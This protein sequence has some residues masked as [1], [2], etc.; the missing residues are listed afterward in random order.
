MGV[1]LSHRFKFARPR[2]SKRSFRKQRPSY[3]F[4]CDTLFLNSTERESR[5][6]YQKHNLSNPQ[7]VREETDRQATRT[8]E[9]VR[10]ESAEEEPGKMRAER[11]YGRN[12][13]YDA[14]VDRKREPPRYGSDEGRRE[15]SRNISINSFKE[16][17]RPSPPGSDRSF[18][19]DA[20]VSVSR[21]CSHFYYIAFSH[22]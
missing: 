19:R 8:S 9:S 1:R 16:A 17:E 3:T 12:F 10:R 13:N 14:Y 6:G 11:Q 5:G 21:N 18:R 15:D 7:W 2:S 20:E 4:K 22:R